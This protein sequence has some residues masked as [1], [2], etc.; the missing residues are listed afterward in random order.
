MTL[1]ISRHSKYLSKGRHSI[2]LVP[3]VLIKMDITNRVG[4]QVWA[5]F[6]R[7]AA[8]FDQAQTTTSD[9]IW[10]SLSSPSMGFINSYFCI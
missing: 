7:S 4:G 8:G 1:A 2:V 3:Q 10:E 5:I 6:G 9:P